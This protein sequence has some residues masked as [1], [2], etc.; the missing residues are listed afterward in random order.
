[1]WQQLGLL[2][3][4]QV[5]LVVQSAA[6]D[7][8]V[9]G[10]SIFCD[11]RQLPVEGR[12]W[13]DTESYY[14]RLPLSAKAAVR[15]PVWRLSKDTSGLLHRFSTDSSRLTVRWILTNDHLERH[16]MSSVGVSGID[17]YGLDESNRWRHIPGVIR[18][19]VGKNEAVYSVGAYREF[20]L[21]LPLR[22]GIQSLEVG[23][24]KGAKLTVEERKRPAVVFYGT[25][26]T[27]GECAS[28]PGLSFPAIVGRRLD[29]EIINLGF[30]GNGR[31]EPEVARLLA[32]LNPDCFVIDPLRNNSP[33]GLRKRYEPFLRQL[34]SA[35]PKT[36]ILLADES[37]FDARGGTEKTK[38]VRSVMEKLQHEG[39]RNLHFLPN[40]G[41]LGNDFEGTVDGV[42]PNDLGMMRMADVFAPAIENILSQRGK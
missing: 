27:Q 41:M 21:Y 4:A 8:R 28:R 13:K 20:L 32:E 15:E 42:H 29:V 2:L 25:S 36:P 9:E 23:I 12:G 5:L 1:M 38:I 37:W 30:S 3:T 7:G 10:D 31:L 26:I 40:L 17:L 16:H 14:N 22:N 35:H 19:K 11:A 18:P 34:L 24:Q 6:F 39:A 33:E